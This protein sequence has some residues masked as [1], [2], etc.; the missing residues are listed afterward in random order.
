MCKKLIYLISFVLVL[1]LAGNVQAQEIMIKF[2][3]ADP[4]DHLWG[5][6]GNWEPAEVPGAGHMPHLVT[7]DP[8]VIIPGGYTAEA[9]NIFMGVGAWPGG[10]SGAMTV[11]DGGILNAAS[12]NMGCG[13]GATGTVTVNSGGT[14]T[15]GGIKVGYQSS[16]DI[17]TFNNSGA[18]DAGNIFFLGTVAGA[19]GTLNMNG[20]TLTANWFSPGYRGTG[21]VYMDSGTITANVGSHI[22]EQG[23]GTFNMTGGLFEAPGGLWIGSFPDDPGISTKGTGYVNL[24]GGIITAGLLEMGAYN[25]APGGDAQIDITDETARLIITGDVR[26]L[27]QGY[28]DDESIIAYGGAG[29]VL[30]DLSMN[31]GSTTVYV[32]EPA[33]IA[34]LGLGG[35]ALL[36]RRKH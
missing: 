13:G 14:I 17:G 22:G 1:S 9:G 11:E 15:A 24:G 34:L 30:Y 3:D 6:A 2:T 29:T 12:I 21:T 20:G 23:L 27:I 28:I 4:A 10:E 36:R 25:G 31:P 35:L 7:V 8:G 26:E 16:G 19:S 33:T 18:T 5:T 32:P